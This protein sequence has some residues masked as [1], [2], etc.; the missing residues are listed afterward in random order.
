MAK[1]TASNGFYGHSGNKKYSNSAASHLYA[2]KSPSTS[3]YRSRMVF[4]SLR[5]FLGLDAGARIAITAMKLYLYRNEGGPTKVYAN[6]SASS[7]W[8]AAIDAYGSANILASTGWHSI[9]MMRC[10]E[11]VAGYTGNWYMHLTGE[12]NSRIRFDGTGSSH[13]PYL[14]ITWEYVAATIKSDK[15]TVELGQSVTFTVTPEVEGETHTMTYTIGDA[16]G[17]IGENFGDFIE[18]A[19]GAAL[20]TEITD[21]DTGTLDISMT[22]YSPDGAVLRTERYF[23]AVKVPEEMAAKVDG[24]GAAL[25]NGLGGYALTGR[26]NAVVAPVIDVNG[27][28][29]ATIKTVTATITNGETEQTTVWTAF[30]ETQPGIFACA[31]VQTFVFNEAGA[32]T[33]RVIVEDSRGFADT[34]ESTLTVCEYMP[35]VITAFS[36]RRY[37]AIYNDD[38]ELDGYAADDLGD[39]VWVN[40]AA[41]ISNVAPADATLNELSWRIDWV[42]PITGETRGALGDGFLKVNLEQDRTVIPEV[43][44][45]QETWN[46]TLTVTDTAGGTAVQYAAVQPGWANFALAASKHG[47]AFGGLPRGTVEKPMLESWYPF[48]AYAAIYDRYNAEV[49]GAQLI[50]DQTQTSVSVPDGSDKVIELFTAEEDGLYIVSFTVG[51]AADAD[52]ARA[53]SIYRMVDGT[54]TFLASSRMIAGGSAALHQNAVALVYAHAGETIYGLMWQNGNNANN[55]HYYYQVAKIGG[56]V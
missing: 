10:A 53:T 51:W 21:D 13:K 15:A 31:P 17:V 18:F 56:N 28:Y 6:C 14:D 34:A 8:G 25:Q 12:G 26:S 36:V 24:V 52:G 50:A 49:I 35:P 19:P 5:S 4:P 16:E 44:P 40:L 45:N 23:Q 32:A 41:E 30:E 38:E 2:G 47:A 27:S 1:P 39:H 37:S 46:Y 29:G 22:A 20:A 11:V 48:Y 33:F 3:N 43:I 54:R 7:E 55:A 42:N 9:D